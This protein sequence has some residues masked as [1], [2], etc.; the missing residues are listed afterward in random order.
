MTT[1]RALSAAF[2]AALLVAG[3]SVNLDGAPCREAGTT[4]D[5]P[6]G[7]ACGNDLRC[8]ARAL[9][10]AGS[11]CTPGEGGACLDPEGLPS[12]VDRARRCTDADRVCG[13]WEL[14]PCA[15][16][17]FVCG[18][19]SGA[20]RCEC[21]EYAGTVVVAGPA[22]SPSRD[23]YPYP[24][25]QES[26]RLC[27]FGKLGD[28][29]DAAGAHTAAA[30]VRI[31]GEAGAAVVFG[32]ATGEAFPLRVGSNVTVLAAP[33][34][35]GP[36][37]IRGAPGAATLVVVQGAAEG[38]RVEAGGATGTGVSLSCGASGA[39]S[40]RQ[41]AVDGGGV[42]L[43][44]D[45]AVT[46]GL[47]AGVVVG[48]TCGARLTGVGV[49]A[50]AGPA[51]SIEPASAATVE[52]LGGRFGGSRVGIRL[53]GGK[54]AVGTDPE[55]AASVAVSGNTSVGVA[56]GSGTGS[57]TVLD[58]ALDGLT[59]AGNG[60]AGV[61]VGGL[62]STSKV[63]ILRCDVR[64][65][66]EVSPEWSGFLAD[67]VRRVGGVLVANLALATF[68]FHGNRLWSN[69]GDQLAFDT[70]ATFSIAP[71]SGTCGPDSNVF[72]WLAEGDLALRQ[73]GPGR[74]GA[75]YNA[76]PG[77]P[78]SAYYTGNVDATSGDACST[79]PGV[80]PWP[81]AP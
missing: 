18:L 36:S 26:P 81:P 48:G 37:V 16:N 25:G 34:P 53:L 30:T 59:I 45:G 13:S 42:V 39:P 68:S 72:A 54:V 32:A 47:S 69:A 20:A 76:W 71:E 46:A 50:V 31:E 74:V 19:R 5:C 77:Y 29:L 63:R 10:C 40:L 28:A 64:G 79:E 75:S 52:V 41:V 62:A 65:N 17:G 7:Q 70:G 3:C 58:A 66:G 80:P 24:R 12:G 15:A 43:D 73:V 6:G 78:P 23:G 51:L 67:G 9:A 11:R 55:S 57:A 22:G 14:E 49:E 27:R 60:G 2:A 56:V 61:V 44:P 21:P 8:S 38:L 1:L 35:A 4:R 33:A